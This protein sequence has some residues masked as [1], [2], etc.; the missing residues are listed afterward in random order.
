[1]INIDYVFDDALCA[2]AVWVA[3]SDTDDADLAKIADM[4]IGARVPMLSGPAN[5][6]DKIWPWLENS[7]VQIFNRFEFDVSG[8]GLSGA[9]QL[10]KDVTAAF[11]CGAYG[12]QIFVPLKNIPDFVDTIL[13]IRNDL[14]FNHGFSVALNLDEQGGPDWSAVFDKIKKLGPDSV[15]V[16]ASGDDFDAKSDFVGR[17]YDMLM[18][19]DLAADLHIF[20]GKNMFR[21]CQVVRMVQKIHPELLSG[22]CAL[23]PP[24][25]IAKE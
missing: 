17:V 4:A 3:R 21:V 16:T 7:S 20:F 13:P 5:V 14:F 8:D 6:T 22:M 19:W 10:A 9:A 2:R 15:L 11:R 24:E 1:M 18:H 25:F 12:A 23:V